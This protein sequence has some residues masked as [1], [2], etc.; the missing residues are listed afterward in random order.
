MTTNTQSP[1]YQ[2][3]RPDASA[4]SP[5]G[6]GGLGGVMD[7]VEDRVAEAGHDA[8]QAIDGKRHAAAES[9]AS[10]ASSLHSGADKAADLGQKGG[11]KV[12]HLAHGAADKLQAGADFVREHDFK[13]M[14]Q[15]VEG[16]V[17]RNPGQ[18]LLAAG[19]VGFFTARAMRN[20]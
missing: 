4:A 15:S 20:D 13:S 18:A 3:S 8:V 16:F 14:M 11:E 1:D 5:D 6:L 2:S 12:S 19:V 9:L 10:A 7:R 17:R